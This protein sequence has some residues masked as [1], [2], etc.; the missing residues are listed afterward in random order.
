M[1]HRLSKIT[2]RT[3][4]KG[5]TGLATGLRVEKD[6]PRVYAMGAVDELNSCMGVVLARCAAASPSRNMRT[7][8]ASFVRRLRASRSA[9]SL[10]SVP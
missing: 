3:V 1:G 2:T 4:D 8:P 7:S 10:R 5:T 6:S 9:L